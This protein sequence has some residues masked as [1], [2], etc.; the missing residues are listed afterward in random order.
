MFGYS[1]TSV[2][3]CDLDEGCKYAIQGMHGNN[4]IAQAPNGTVYVVDSL[5]GALSILEKQADHTLVL[6]DYIEAGKWNKTSI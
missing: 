5:H 2:V 1:A 6:T 3:Y 4:G